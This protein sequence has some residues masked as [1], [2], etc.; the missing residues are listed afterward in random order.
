ME[1]KDLPKGWLIL[2]L[3]ICMTILRAINVDTFVTAALS[4]IVFYL[5]GRHLKEA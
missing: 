1:I 4:G 5:L 3:M 2:A